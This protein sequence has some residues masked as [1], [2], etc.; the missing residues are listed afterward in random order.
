MSETPQEPK[1]CKCKPCRTCGMLHSCNL[2]IPHPG[3]WVRVI[4][5]PR[6]PAP[7]ERWSWK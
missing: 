7:R 2:S 1:P 6:C 3:G 4:G 5:E